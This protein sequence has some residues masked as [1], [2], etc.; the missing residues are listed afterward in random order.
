MKSTLLNGVHLKGFLSFGP[1]SEQIELTKLNVLIG[2]NGVGKSNFIEAMELLH[3]TPADFSGAIRIGGTPTDWIWRGGKGTATARIEALVSPV[4]GI[5]ELRYAIEFAESATRLEIVDEVLEEAEKADLK[6]KD[7]RFYYRFQRGRPAINVSETVTD[8]VSHREYKQRKLKRENIDPQQSIFSQMKDPDLYPEITTTAKRFGAMQVFREWSFGRSAAL[9]AA[10]PAN[11]PTD[12]L[13]PQLVNLGLVLNDLEHRAEWSRFNELMRK[14]LPRYQRLSTK[15]SAGAVQVY[16]HEEGL[17]APVAATRLSD[18]TLRFLALLAILLS[19]ETAPLI[20]IEE[21]E[22]GLHPDAMSLLADLLTEASEKTQ[23]IV[24][25]HSDVL[26]SALTEQAESV[27]VCEYLE[28]GT[29]LRRLE[30]A[31]LKHWMAKYRLGEVWR[32]GK[33]GGN[34]W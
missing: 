7:V 31:K 13:L 33:L 24:T 10:Q 32:L 19:P 18:G 25:T 21:P 6:A 8:T 5:P 12:V 30:S 16:L 15:V 17:K 27:L 28:N 1:K 4:N 20:C 3:A 34:L 2:P 26:I 23:L 11:L 29:E 9:R 22:L 14:F